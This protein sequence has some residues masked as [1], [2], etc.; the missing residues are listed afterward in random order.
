MS[1]VDLD[2][3][4]YELR[5]RAMQGLDAAYWPMPLAPIPAPPGL[6]PHSSIKAVDAEITLPQH[7]PSLQAPKNIMCSLLAMHNETERLTARHATQFEAD[8][9][10]TMAE[11]DDLSI[12]KDEAIQNEAD[13]VK[14][15][16]TWS[17]LA[18]I[19]EY[20]TGIAAII[21]GTAIYAV[22]AVP[23]ALIIAAGA[24]GTT[25][26]V[27]HDTHVLKTFVEWYTKSV[28]LQKK[29]TNF[30]ETSAFFLQL[31]LGL[32]GGIGAWK[33]GAFAAA[34]AASAN[35][36][37]QKFSSIVAPASGVV[38]AGAT[39]GTKIYEKRISDANATIKELD[40]DI[41][42]GNH[43][44]TKESGKINRDIEDTESE[45]EVIRRAI[46]N[47]EVSQD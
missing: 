34:N 6:S 24:I 19:A 25:N 43:S 16:E 8:V 20:I 21:L 41:S 32:A 36:I 22:A 29:I 14:T 4:D 37:V 45:V 12:K 5:A 31:G 38:S 2:L 1:S 23:G 30:V 33:A 10:K 26:R 39:V 3:D 7:R 40:C 15:R 46:K 13:L 44:I 47:L 27:I 17:A 9:K 18:T 28:D 42:T 35:D 11:I